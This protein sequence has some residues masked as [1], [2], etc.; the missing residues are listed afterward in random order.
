MI[1]PI[2]IT[3]GPNNSIIIR[4]CNR[5]AKIIRRIAVIRRQFGLL[6]PCFTG[7]LKNVSGTRTF[8]IVIITAS[9]YNHIMAGNGNRLAKCVA[10]NTVIGSDFGLLA[11]CCASALE[12]VGRPR[13]SAVILIIMRP[14][15][16]VI[17][18]KRRRYTKLLA[19][20]PIARSYFNLI[21]A[22]N[23]CE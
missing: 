20:F 3:L 18:G 9:P 16:R 21:R 11:P 17:A 15:N 13:I 10:F 19:R 5:L 7:A 8:P 12:Y 23:Q 2:P 6:A 4:H 1:G 14:K 22:C